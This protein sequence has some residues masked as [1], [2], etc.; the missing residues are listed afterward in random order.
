MVRRARRCRGAR[1]AWLPQALSAASA[2]VI[3]Q[4]A[5]A[6]V[7]SCVLGLMVGLVK[8]AVVVF[9]RGLAG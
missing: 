3:A 1:D 8:G 7:A 5:R 6:R 2:R 9:M 4:G